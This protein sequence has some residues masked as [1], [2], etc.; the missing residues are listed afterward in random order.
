M[1]RIG[2][3]MHTIKGMDDNAFLREIAALGFTA[4]FMK[5]L[6]LKE[7]EA[8]AAL[9]AKHGICC[10]TL[11]APFSHINDIWLPGEGG[12]AMLAE[13]REAVEHCLIAGAKI[14][15]VHLSSGVNAPPVTDIG[16]LRFGKLVEYARKRGVKI[17]F[18]NQRKL[19]NL[20]WAMET[21]DDA[22]AGFCWDCGHEQSLAGGMRYMPLFGKRLITTHIHD[23]HGIADRD[24]HLIPFD[25]TLDYGYVARMLREANYSGTL[26]LELYRRDRYSNISP[27]AY[28][29]WA[30]KA[31]KRLRSMV[32]GEEI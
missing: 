23:N 2:M 20:A 24:E 31:A 14:A 30:A 27:E 5:T 15:V 9:C 11:H 25:G 18:E 22:A 32:D 26:M 13:L 21:F 17:A 10:E 28:L 7:Q 6:P 3:N 29:A 12:D 1:R 19:A 16:R 8:A 4:T